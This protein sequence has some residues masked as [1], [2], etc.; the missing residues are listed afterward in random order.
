MTRKI[1]VPL[2]IPN[3]VNPTHAVNKSQLDGSLDDRVAV[4]GDVMTGA[5]GMSNQQIYNLAAGT[6]ADHAVNKAQLDALSVAPEVYVGTSPPA[7]AETVWYDTDAVLPAALEPT[8][9]YHTGWTA[10]A[11]W[12]LT[13][14]LGW[15]IGNMV[16]LRVVATRINTAITV[17]DLTGEITNTPVA[18]APPELRGSISQG[19]SLAAGATGMLVS[20]VYYAT[21]GIVEICATISG[22][23]DIT[24]GMAISIG[25]TVIV[26]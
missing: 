15:R 1:L 14:T 12:T 18:I 11:D 5:L 20:G 22:T 17:T 26:S 4:A 2:D 7:G 10:S 9:T 16:M 3:G 8:P 13:S 6:S 21:S 19:M 23:Q 25:G 24:V